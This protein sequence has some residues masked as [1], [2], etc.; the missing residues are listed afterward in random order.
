[1]SYSSTTFSS[2]KSRNQKRFSRSSS[3]P[4]IQDQVSTTS[5][6]NFTESEEQYEVFRKQIKTQSEDMKKFVQ[7][8]SKHHYSSKSDQTI[9]KLQEL[10][11]KQSNQNRR[12]MNENEK[13]TYQVEQL[14]KE[15]CSLQ[16]ELNE[17]EKNY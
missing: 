15:N 7:I 14:K 4:P 5:S 1:M 6:S 8:K 12:V 13:L 9:Q 10:V 16:S 17:K 3:S 11:Q 2:T